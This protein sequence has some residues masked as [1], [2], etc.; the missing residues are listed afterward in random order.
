[1]GMLVNIGEAAKALG[2]H[3]ETL[4][5]WEKE[6]LIFSLCDRFGTDVVLIEATEGPS[7]EAEL[8]QDVLEIITGFSA[9]LYGSRSPK[10]KTLMDCMQE[11]TKP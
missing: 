8:V 1:M 10:P 2:V 11:V 6:D 9:R 4:R 7:F 5:R 3:P